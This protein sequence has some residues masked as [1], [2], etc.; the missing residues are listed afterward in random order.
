MEI[1]VDRPSTIYV[2]HE[3]IRNGGFDIS[4]LNTGWILVTDNATLLL[5]KDANY[6]SVDTGCIVVPCF[7]SVRNGVK[8]CSTNCCTYKY[9][10]KMVVSKSGRTVVTLPETTTS[11]TV[12]HIFVQSIFGI[13]CILKL[14]QYD[15]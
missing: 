9:I 7:C 5:R 14:F 2:A 3:Q 4:L 11:E 6:A 12:L 10:W 8:S 13:Y 15:S 1:V